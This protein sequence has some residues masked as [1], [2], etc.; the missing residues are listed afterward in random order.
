MVQTENVHSRPTLRAP[1]PFPRRLSGADLTF[2][3][4]DHTAQQS[5]NGLGLRIR[6]AK[7]VLR[8]IALVEGDISVA[9]CFLA[10][11][12]RDI[13]EAPLVLKGLTSMRFSDIS[14]GRHRGRSHLPPEITVFIERR[15]P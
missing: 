1:H 4:R 15:I 5:S 7:L 13:Q 10:G 14:H 12:R 11:S 9:L 2:K 6:V 8:F 3:V